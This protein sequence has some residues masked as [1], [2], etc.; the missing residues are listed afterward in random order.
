MSPISWLASP[1]VGTAGVLGG[2]SLLAIPLWKLTSAKPLLA[3]AVDVT[4]LA[5]HQISA[6]LRLRLLAPV[7]RVSVRTSDGH[8][9]LQARELAAGESE[10][11]V[12]L[13]FRDHHVSLSAEA[14][15]GELATDTAIFFTVM[16]DGY[17]DQTRYTIG[18]G[19][20]R[21]TLDYEWLTP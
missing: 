15:F 14:D 9:L 20:L 6:V 13:P 10:Y 5:E 2:L 3:P 21:D 1:L 19:M 7:K 11:D 4:K 12:V 16:P 18:H 8:E 17:E